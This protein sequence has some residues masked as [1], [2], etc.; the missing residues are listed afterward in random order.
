VTV[1]QAEPDRQAP[2]V[3]IVVPSFNQARYLETALRSVLEQDYPYLE[4]IVIDGGSTDGSRAI[5]E[6][7]AP[8][9]AYWVSEPDAGQADGINKGLRRATGEIVAWL[10]SDDVY[11]PGAI[12][13]AVETLAAEPDAG[14]V[15]ADGI[16]VDS[17]QVLLDWHRYRPLELVDLL[18]FE[19]LLQPTVF[20]RRS[21]LEEAGHL[22]ASYQLILDHE[23]WV[24]MAAR[25]RLRHV[26][27][28][29][30]LE[31]THAEA[32]TIAHAA[33]FVA[34]A[35]RLLARAAEDP[36]LAAAVKRHA[37]RIDAG[38]NVFAA[39]RLIDAG[40]YRAAFGHVL[41]ALRR[42]PPTVARYWYK[43]VQAAGSALGLA[44]LFFWYRRTRRRLQH[45]RQIVRAAA[46]DSPAGKD[47]R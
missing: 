28:F 29:W 6:R 47:P 26:R 31:R 38:F 8:R 42:H 11:L 44:G 4:V 46:A 17:D 40:Q 5:L 12:R 16:M 1:S 37:R 41:Y 14:L 3:S 2:K 39:R 30:A 18:S 22:D 24:R 21:L 27:S 13:Q 25:A 10:N 34:E 9:L 33:E 20:M 45:G 32:K 43:F 35:R 36:L 7:Y 23:L 19:V 15:Y